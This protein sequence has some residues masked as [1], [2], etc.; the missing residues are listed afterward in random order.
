MTLW[1]Y[2]KLEESADEA[3][4]Q[5][6]EE[7]IRYTPEELLPDPRHE[8]YL[9]VEGFEFGPGDKVSPPP[10]P[11]SERI[12]RLAEAAEEGPSYPAERSLAHLAVFDRA[13]AVRIAQQWNK[14][15]L[16]E[17]VLPLIHA[18]LQFPEPGSLEA[19][20]DELGLTDQ[21]HLEL[22]ETDERPVTLQELLFHR[23]R[24]HLFSILRRRQAVPQEEL[25]CEL[26]ALAPGVF[27]GFLFEQTPPPEEVPGSE[28][29]ELEA[30]LLEEDEEEDTSREYTLAERFIAR[31]GGKRY[32]AS[33][34]SE[35]VFD[36]SF[37]DA[38][39]LLDFLN[40]LARARGSDVRWVVFDSDRQDCVVVAGPAP[41]F[42]A[43]QARGLIPETSPERLAA[44]LKASLGEPPSHQEP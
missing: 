4:S 17:P 12:R 13:A 14:L 38:G 2:S 34:K 7:P 32:E 20:L 40:A 6:P 16:P 23:G 5:T 37:M 36:D 30:Q 21:F 33:A 18:L 8:L 24:A 31:G 44:L 28:D 42:D 10:F 27:D 41:A 26:A 19:Y 35:F 43:L 29:A 3:S 39:T 25:L 9:E 1:H 15:Q 22:R 11:L